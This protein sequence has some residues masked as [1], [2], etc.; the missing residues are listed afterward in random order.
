MFRAGPTFS[1]KDRRNRDPDKE[2]WC[3]QALL[4]GQLWSDYGIPWADKPTDHPE[5]KGSPYDEEDM[6]CVD[7]EVARSCD[8]VCGCFKKLSQAVNEC[9]IP[10]AAAPILRGSIPGANSNSYVGWL[11]RDCAG[12]GGNGL[13]GEERFPKR[14]VNPGYTEPLPEC[15]REKMEL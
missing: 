4:L 15:V 1:V 9:C 2:C 11:L 7:L 13:P 5:Y 12:G 14:R 6:W 8:D 10:Y 3:N